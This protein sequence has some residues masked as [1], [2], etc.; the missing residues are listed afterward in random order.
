MPRDM[1]ASPVSAV[2]GVQ[3]SKLSAGAREGGVGGDDHRCAL[4]GMA[5][6]SEGMLDGKAFR[7]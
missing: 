3:I 5:L 1:K 2:L 7:R 4:F 6:E